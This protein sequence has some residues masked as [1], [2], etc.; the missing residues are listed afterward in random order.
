MSALLKNTNAC[1]FFI[2]PWHICHWNVLVLL[3]Y[4]SAAKSQKIDGNDFGC[5]SDLCHVYKSTMISCWGHVSVLNK[6]SSTLQWL[7]QLVKCT[8]WIDIT[9]KRFM[10]LKSERDA[11]WWQSCSKLSNQLNYFI[12]YCLCRPVLLKVVDIDPQGSIGL[13]KES[14]NGHWVKWGSL[15]GP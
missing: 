10:L 2:W 8:L 1:F 5:L 7:G 4:I 11:F 12:C 3:H 14:I 9:F 6:M 15:N 13:S